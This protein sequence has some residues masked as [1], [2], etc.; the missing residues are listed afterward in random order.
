MIK[1]IYDYLED[2]NKNNRLIASNEKI[3]R[4]KTEEFNRSL[5][6][7][8]ESINDLKD[9]NNKI[10]TMT[11]KAELSEVL[12]N[13]AKIHGVAVEDIR[14]TYSSDLDLKTFDENTAKNYESN[15]NRDKY[16]FPSR[17]K[18]LIF[19]EFPR[20]TSQ[21][22]N[23]FET[24]NTKINLDAIQKDGL[25]FVQHIAAKTL[26]TDKKEFDVK[27]LIDD[28]NQLIIETKLQMLIY[29][30]SHKGM[31]PFNHSCKAIIDAS[32]VYNQKT[33]DEMSM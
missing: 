21:Y 11:I 2:I 20:E 29:N 18:L 24:I 28:I 5:T 33:Q 31:M 16:K 27:I 23:R 19:I 14:V 6:S 8:H 17:L 15:F 12:R 3:I 4:E 25:M 32:E 10:Q 22:L 1:S 7:Y 13:F 26:S 30:D 9:E